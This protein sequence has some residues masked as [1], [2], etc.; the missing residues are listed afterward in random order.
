MELSLSLDVNK[1]EVLLK[2]GH[3]QL[4]VSFKILRYC[5]VPPES[6]DIGARIHDCSRARHISPTTNQAIAQQ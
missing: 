6:R 4:I 1:P 2:E 3:E 5:D